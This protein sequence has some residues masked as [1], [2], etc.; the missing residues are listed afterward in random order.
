MK[1]FILAFL[2]APIVPLLVLG[3]IDIA[4]SS[5]VSRHSGNAGLFAVIMFLYVYPT[6]AI[7]GLP[8]FLLFRRRGWYQWWR[9]LVGGVCIGVA[10]SLLSLL[11]VL[12]VDV[13]MHELMATWLPFAGLGAAFGA[14]GALA[15]RAI[16]FPLHMSPGHAFDG[17]PREAHPQ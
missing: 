17:G 15:F 12:F 4:G 5:G 7:L 8:V 3:L 2:V 11:L 9:V 10:P 6:T 13:G 14:I 1:R 16:A